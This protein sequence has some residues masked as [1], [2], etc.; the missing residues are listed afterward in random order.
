MSSRSSSTKLGG[1]VTGEV[2]FNLFT[3][4]A[5][6]LLAALL[7]LLVRKNPYETASGVRIDRKRTVR[8]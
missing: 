2:S 3:V 4:V 5:A 7:Y 8:A 1:L 6:A